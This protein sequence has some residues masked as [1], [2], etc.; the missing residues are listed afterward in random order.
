MAKRPT[1][2]FLKLRANRSRNDVVMAIFISTAQRAQSVKVPAFTGSKPDATP[3]RVCLIA[4]AFLG[5]YLIMKFSTIF[6]L[7][8]SSFFARR[9][10]TV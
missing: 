6:A 8:C 7:A 3:M 2:F 4:A 9:Q 5:E 1:N 10:E